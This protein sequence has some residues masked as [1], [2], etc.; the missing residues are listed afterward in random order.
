MGVSLWESQTKQN[1]E[2]AGLFSVMSSRPILIKN[3]KSA[4]SGNK[5]L[6]E[7][8]EAA[9]ELLFVTSWHSSRPVQLVVHLYKLTTCQSGCS[10]EPPQEGNA[11][12][13]LQR[14]SVGFFFPCQYWAALMHIST[15]LCLLTGVKRS[16]PSQSKHLV[17]RW[18]VWGEIT[19]GSV[20]SLCFF[21]LICPL[22][23]HLLAL[24]PWGGV[25]CN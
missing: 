2:A 1:K 23:L 14:V 19:G 21:D 12:D 15:C 9:S 18:C 4:L 25:Q 16:G 24:L 13:S 11:S 6:K 20:H 7:P 17:S 10:V 22:S 3:L 8:S 5:A